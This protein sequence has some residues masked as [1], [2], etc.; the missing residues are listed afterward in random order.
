MVMSKAHPYSHTT[1]KTNIQN[2]QYKTTKGDALLT[3]NS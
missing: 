1:K 3:I 2:V